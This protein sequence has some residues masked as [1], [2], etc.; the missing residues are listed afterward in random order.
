MVTCE[1]K[2]FQNYFRLC[3]CP[4]GVIS[5]QLVEIVPEIISELFHRLTA[6][7]EYYPTRSLS[8]K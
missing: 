8:L 3:Q 7:Q 4:S 2:L 6:A 1:I 5:F